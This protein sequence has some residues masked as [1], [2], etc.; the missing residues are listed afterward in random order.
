MASGDDCAMVRPMSDDGR[1][2]EPSPTEGARKWLQL[3]VIAGFL[4]L[5]LSHAMSILWVGLL[6]R[7]R[8]EPFAFRLCCDPWAW[9]TTRFFLNPRIRVIGRENLP[10]SWKGYLF[11]SNHESL[12]DIVLLTK[13]VR[14]AF[15]MK[16]SVL[17][18]PIGW[19]T[20]FSGSVAFDRSSKRERGR[21]LHET[22]EMAERAMS[23]IVFP[24]G[25]YGHRDGRL[26]KPHL[27]LLRRAYARG[28]PIVPLGHAG[29]RRAVDGESLPVRRGMDLVL[30][31]RPPVM[32]QAYADA[33]TFAEACWADVKKAVAQARSAIAPG[34]PYRAEP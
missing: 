16:K 1:A 33:A 19:G 28:L 22:L 20:Y 4:G 25:T 15:L 13:E 26:R 23:V 29:C 31:V 24:E 30:V 9:Y 17:I 14:R 18:S 10:R 32:P 3:P 8:R 34:W 2:F 21:A 6:P 5:C 11:V 7:Y 12:V 27:Q